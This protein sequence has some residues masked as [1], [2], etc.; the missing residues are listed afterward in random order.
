MTQGLIPEGVYPQKQ[1]SGKLKSCNAVF[2]VTRCY[3][4]KCKGTLC[5]ELGMTYWWCSLLWSALLHYHN[6]TLHSTRLGW[7]L[8]KWERP[9][10]K[11]VLLKSLSFSISFLFCSCWLVACNNLILI[12]L[13]Q[14]SS[15]NFLRKVYPFLQ[16]EHN[17]NQRWSLCICWS[18]HFLYYLI[19]DFGSSFFLGVSEDWYE[20]TSCLL[21]N[22]LS[23][24]TL[25]FC[26]FTL[27]V[28]RSLCVTHRKQRKAS[29]FG[30]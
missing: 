27:N 23:Q 17:S 3:S 28:F 7:F 1:S 26:I 18:S 11:V 21:F 16:Q 30:F 6:Q 19:S 8:R 13:F 10:K 4:V 9:G 12:F 2:I 5:S 24:G 22:N 25:S 14:G 20:D 15:T 29:P